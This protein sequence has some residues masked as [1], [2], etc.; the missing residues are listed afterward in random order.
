VRVPRK[1]FSPKEDGV[2]EGWRKLDNEEVLNFSLQKILLGC[3]NQEAEMGKPC[4]TH[5]GMRNAY[6]ILVVR[7]EVIRTLRRPRYGWEDNI[8][9]DLKEMGG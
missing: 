3:S 1:I 5:A 6:K 2:T 7:P 8:K 4:S 9:M